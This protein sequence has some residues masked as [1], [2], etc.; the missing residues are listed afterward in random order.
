MAGPEQNLNLEKP[1]F[2][3]ASLLSLWKKEIFLSL[4]CHHIGTIQKFNP[5]AQ[6][7][8]I[9]IQYKKTQYVKGADGVYKKKLV[10]YPILLDCPV[11]SLRG[12]GL[13][14]KVSY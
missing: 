9:S 13:F 8:E 12:G 11:I 4:N 3:L 1:D 5:G 7:A 2:D 14:P 6:T 10:D